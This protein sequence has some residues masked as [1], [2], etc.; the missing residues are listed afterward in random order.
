MKVAKTPVEL[1]KRTLGR[2]P[3]TRSHSQ[4]VKTVYVTVIPTYNICCIFYEIIN[5][6]RIDDDLDG[7]KCRILTEA[8]EDLWRR[9]RFSSRPSAGM[10]MMMIKK[11]FK[12]KIFV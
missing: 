8:T 2:P 1:P 10:I 7:R 11:I 9:F 4:T 6:K 5:K 12:Y 3:T